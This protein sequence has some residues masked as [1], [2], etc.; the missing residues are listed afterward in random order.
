MIEYQ[1]QSIFASGAALAVARERC[2]VLWNG[3]TLTDFQCKVWD[4]GLTGAEG[5]MA[6]NIRTRLREHV[7]PGFRKQ[8]THHDN[9][10]ETSEIN[11]KP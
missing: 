6:G 9:P 1:N 11:P 4:S 3:R 10:V 8:F 2:T 7:R 5:G